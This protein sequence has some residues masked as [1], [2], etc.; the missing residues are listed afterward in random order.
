MKAALPIALAA[1]CLIQPPAALAQTQ[2]EAG[3]QAEQSM[4]ESRADDVVAV[5]NGELPAAD[6]FSANFLAA[7]SE[8]QLEIMNAQLSAQFGPLLA[9]ESVDPVSST[10]A[11]VAFRFERATGS[12]GM[13]IGAAPPFLIEGLRLSSFA[14]IDD[15]AAKI[16]A[17]L[18][19]LPGQVSVY[20]GPLEGGE[21]LFARD[22]ATAYPI[23]STFKLYVL[24]A[25]ARSIAAGERAWSDVVPL[26]VAS[27]PS[28]RLHNWPQGTP[29]TLQSLATMMIAASDNTATDQLI[30]VLG[31]AAV[32]AE[33]RA[34]GHG[35]PDATLPF[36][37]TLE[38]FALK[39]RTKRGA[40]YAE[41]S[42]DE[43]QELIEALAAEL[44]GTPERT[45]ITRWSEARLIEE[46][47]WFADMDD[48]RRILARL[49]E[50]E[51]P[52]AR[53][54][55]AVNQS[56]PGAIAR[57]W[58]YI[59]YKGGSEPGVLNF[60]WLLR[61]KQGAWQMLAMSWKDESNSLD[62]QSFQ[63]FAQRII[64]LPRD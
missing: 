20:F 17:D 62:E 29:I 33:L 2:M 41:A 59:G 48:L 19:D 38:M 13:E 8:Q 30:A 18:D 11:R 47:E 14:A 35:D 60:T 12:G 51:D 31:R 64:A 10:G 43:Q 52:V 45:G 50:L 42:E 54:I 15:D 25:L 40:A 37:T 61:D 7:V 26:S 58:D 24:S 1:L 27:L 6:V 49:A 28:G 23:G 16:A 63:L 46:V 56:F 55:M 34:S 4:L 21:P 36:L 5:L 39:T 53:Q 32:E 3:A 9:V 57:K 22:V 44:N